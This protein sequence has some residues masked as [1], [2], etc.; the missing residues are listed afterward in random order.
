MGKYKYKC[1]KRDCDYFVRFA[2]EFC[3]RHLLEKYR[4]HSYAANE[5]DE[6]QQYIKEEPVV[7]V[8][9]KL[10]RKLRKKKG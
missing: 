3:D 10:E 8:I 7:E 5:L 2:G 1:H 9:R 4:L 6:M